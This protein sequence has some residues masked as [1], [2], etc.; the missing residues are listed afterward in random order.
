MV[1]ADRTRFLQI[2]MNLGSN[3]LKY[4]RP[5]G[6]VRFEVSAPNGDHVRVSVQDTG[7]G[8]PFDKQPAIF[9]PFQRAGQETGPIEG[10]GIGLVITKRLASLMHGDVDFESTPGVGSRFWVTLPAHAAHSPSSRPLPVELGAATSLQREGHRLVLYVEDNPANAL[11]M[12]DL[13]GNFESIDLLVAPNAE[14]GVE[15]AARRCPAVVIMD[16]NLPGMSGLDALRELKTRRETRDI[17]VIALTAAAS[18]RDRQAGERAG[19]YRYL[20]KPV[21]VDELLSALEALIK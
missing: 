21:Q 7:I 6:S 13:L 5:F 17:P 9:Q 3:A 19:F 10:T 8:I 15:I 1:S 14:A 16:I 11:F 12:Q 20:T 2:L 18:E 4:N